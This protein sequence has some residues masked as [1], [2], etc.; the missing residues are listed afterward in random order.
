MTIAD[1][2]AGS[3]GRG[4]VEI[5]QGPL[6]FVADL[7]KPLTREQLTELG[8]VAALLERLLPYFEE[9]NDA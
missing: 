8:S 6:R 2:R 1:D 9:T 7:N 5:R 3:G 4:Y